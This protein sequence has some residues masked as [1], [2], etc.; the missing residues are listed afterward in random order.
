[1]ERMFSVVVVVIGESF[2]TQVD[3]LDVMY[4]LSLFNLKIEKNYEIFVKFICGAGYH[5]AVVATAH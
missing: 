3:N 2:G 5:T 1:M 4:L